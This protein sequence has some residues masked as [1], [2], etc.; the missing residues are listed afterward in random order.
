MRVFTIPPSR[1]FLRALID[2]LIDGR[3]VEGFEARGD[4]G[5]LADVSLYLPTRRACRLARDTFLEAIDTDAV[6]LPRIVALGDVDEDD[7]VFAQS[8]DAEASLAIPPA[9]GGM[10]RRLL[11]ARLIMHWAEQAGGNAPGD[12]PT[13]IA[14][15]A[16]ALRLADDL[17]RLMDDM[18]TRGVN[19]DGLDALV[20]EEFDRYWQLTLAF[21]K[22][23]R[24]AWPEILAERGAIEPAERRD[25]LI[26]AE[27]DLLRA[28]RGPV[29]AAGSTGSMPATAR[30]LKAVAELADG[31]VVLP[32]LDLLL[33]DE[34]WDLIAGADARPRGAE[35]GRPPVPPAHG[36]PQYAMRA[37]LDRFGVTRA[38]VISLGAGETTARETLMSETM[39]PASATALWSTRLARAPERA[40]IAR[41]MA[42]LAIVEAANPEEEALAIAV[43]LREAA[44]ANSSAALVTP[45]RELARRVIAALARWNLEFDDSGGD[46]LPQTPAG[47]FARLVAE[48]GLDGFAPLPLLALLK[49]SLFRGG[50]ARDGHRDAI[51]ALELAALRGPRRAPGA[52]ALD[53]ALADFAEDHAKLSRGEASALRKTDPA[54]RLTT[55]AI[56]EARA[57]VALL[58]DILAP[59]ARRVA[60]GGACLAD[61]AF[62]H[63]AAIEALA[64]EDDH[65][66]AAYEGDDGAAL[67]GAFEELLD[68]GD[69]A[70][71]P[72]DADA[73]AD[74][75]EALIAGRVVRRPGAPEA[76]LRILGP[77]EARLTTHDRVII[78]G[79][80]E[81]GWPP[82]THTDPWL[83]RPMR[84]HLGLDLPE[85]R[86]GL[87]AHDLVQ[88]MG[89]RRCIL[90]RAARKG[91][92]PT[93]A[94]RFLHRLKAVGGETAWLEALERGRIYL[95]WARALDRAASYAPV[96]RPEPKP[97]R[98]ARPTRLSVTEI[99]AWLRDPYT[100][101]ARHV[102]GLVPLAA[103]DLPPGPAERG[104]AIHAAI[105]DFAQ[106]RARSNALDDARG[107]REPSSTDALARL[108][109]LGRARFAPLLAN[110]EA[111]ALWWPRFVRIATWLVNDWE[112]A[113]RGDI[114]AIFAEI[115]G[116]LSF[117][118]GDRA[119]TLTARA[120]RIERRPDGSYVILDY[121]T[122]SVPTSKQVRAGL[123]PQL[124]LEAAILRA[125]GFAGIDAGASVAG[126][127]YVRLSGNEPAGEERPV[128]LAEKDDVLTPDEAAGKARAELEE[129]VRRFDAPDTPYRSLVLPM[130]QDRYGEYDHLA[131]VKEWSDSGG[132]TGGE[133]QS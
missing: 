87:S 94:S 24:V 81:G 28:R 102:L 128:D 74:A 85:R 5:R 45:D 127:V 125:G 15:P 101:H 73:Y 130:W 9:I 51:V 95:D 108:I 18:T 86:I 69:A 80:V 133:A 40:A 104:S 131:R 42:E 68:A 107:A 98:A 75:F 62:D 70:L 90:T 1:P 19:W 2:A 84:Q 112:A 56:A 89:A 17:A 118:L 59:L 58:A 20:P 88:L 14:G 22:V 78:G 7:L 66:V 29:I 60:T 65:R 93:V 3:L 120:D 122:G 26:A 23:A 55:T 8:A 82:E 106:E 33:D 116:N 52:A 27:A 117:P 12:E 11:L 72:I 21:L 31:A 57:L 36:H 54:A 61:I 109:E 43:A 49:H 50:R 16:S 37:L 115:S 123:S 103:I 41:A 105:G 30:F 110:A 44:E 119:F 79:L 129:L 32:G 71:L 48:V 114:A 83:N 77:L 99:D 63:R 53:A 76:R 92:A 97:P 25:R 46:P 124:L 4:P 113:R 10:E 6:I 67:G 132:A 13:V 35:R 96:A 111:R 126:L 100:I 39:R 38:D 64:R 34:S 47:V 91:T 121:K